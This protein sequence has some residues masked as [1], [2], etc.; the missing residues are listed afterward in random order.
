MREIVDEGA[1]GFAR[2]FKSGFFNLKGV[3]FKGYV[4]GKVVV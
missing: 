3:I 4:G 2:G 1:S